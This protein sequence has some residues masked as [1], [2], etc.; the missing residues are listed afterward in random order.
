MPDPA[1]PD[2]RQVAN[3]LTRKS[4]IG[5]AGIFYERGL[6]YPFPLLGVQYFNFDL[7][8]KNKQ[9]SVFFFG[10]LLFANY[11]DPSFLGT[12]FDLG[13]DAFGVAIPFTETEYR[14]GQEFKAGIRQA[15]AR[16][17]FRSTS[18]IR[19]GTYLKASLDPLV[20]GTTGTRPPSDTAPDVRRAR[21]H[22]HARRR[23]AAELERRTATTSR[24]TP[25]TTP[26]RSGSPGALPTSSPTSRRRRTTGSGLVALHEGLLLRRTSASSS[27]RSRTSAARTS[28]AGRSGTSA[29]SRRLADRISERHRARRP[30][31]C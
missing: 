1:K 18:A 20:A 17:T 14:V 21:R 10:S 31:P 25:A 5:V 28:T 26:G 7:W 19:S 27:S 8:G 30:R 3:K 29:R 2:E 15:S 4:L 24:P 11:T 9:L 22:V 12:H 16:S 13:A 23:A 6:D